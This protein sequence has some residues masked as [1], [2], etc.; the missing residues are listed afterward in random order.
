VAN[1]L[2]TATVASPR[3]EHVL[4]PIRLGQSPPVTFSG[5]D[6]LD[7]HEGTVGFRFLRL[8]DL[9]TI[10]ELA[11]E[12]TMS[13]EQGTW[14]GYVAWSAVGTSGRTDGATWLVGPDDKLTVTI[15]G[16]VFDR[17]VRAFFRLGNPWLWALLGAPAAVAG[18]WWWWRKRR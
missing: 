3:V 8:N 12:R 15:P 6:L 16:Y 11:P 1:E 10:K 14:R 4:K 9:V 13:D 2:T 18:V 5:A 7:Q 17:P